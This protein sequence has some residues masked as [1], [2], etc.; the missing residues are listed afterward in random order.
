MKKCPKV[1]GVEFVNRTSYIGNKSDRNYSESIITFLVK[2]SMNGVQWSN[3]PTSVKL[4]TPET[5][6]SGRNKPAHRCVR[7][8]LILDQ[9]EK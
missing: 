6:A 1:R 2:I 7:P 8:P 3:I 5:T 4:A 9:M